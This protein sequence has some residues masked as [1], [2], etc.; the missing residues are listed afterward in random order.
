[1]FS[2]EFTDDPDE[3]ADNDNCVSLEKL[4]NETMRKVQRDEIDDILD[5]KS[6]YSENISHRPVTPVVKVVPLQPPFQSSATPT[7]LE[8]RYMMWNSVGI[9]RAHKSD[10]EN[11]IEVEFHD[12]SVHHG[13]H[14]TNYLNHT[15]ASL[16]TTVLALSG[17]TPR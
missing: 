11:S 13:I 17:E 2:V 14:I 1:M 15:M 8:H 10:T 6:V 4:K 3:D 5:G 16:S 7:S 12:A 9:V